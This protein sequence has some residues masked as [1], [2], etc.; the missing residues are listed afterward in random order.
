M[1]IQAVIGQVR[2]TSV[3]RAEQSEILINSKITGLDELY[4]KPRFKFGRD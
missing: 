4:L 3:Y 1:K 2:P